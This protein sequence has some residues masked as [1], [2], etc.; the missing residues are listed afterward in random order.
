MT[1]VTNLEKGL[2]AYQQGDFHSA[3][4]LLQ[5]ALRQAPNDPTVLSKLGNALKRS[6]RF[7]EALK[8][9]ETLVQAYPDAPEALSDLGATLLSWGKIEASIGY[10]QKAVALRPDSA[11]LNYNLAVAE[12]YADLLESAVGH[13]RACTS[14]VPT[15]AQAWSNLGICLK[16]LGCT[17]EALFCQQHAAT[18][19]PS[20][21]DIQW[22][23]SLT[24]LLNGNYQSGFARYE[25]RRKLPGYQIVKGKLW[26]G[27]SAPNQMLTVVAEQGLGDTLQ[28][29]RYLPMAKSRV[30]HLRLMSRKALIPLL[31][32]GFQAVDE[33]VP[34]DTL[35]DDTLTAPLMSLPHLLDLPSPLPESV[36]YLRAE[37]S[38]IDYWT[39]LLRLDTS[40]H[41]GIAWQGNPAHRDDRHRSIS[42]QTLSPILGL[43]EARFFSL[44]KEH[45]LFELNKTVT[46]LNLVDIG[47]ALDDDGAFVDTAAVMNVLDL[48]L[49]V[50]TSVAHLAGA[51]GVE[52]W[53]LLPYAPDFRW[54][55]GDCPLYPQMR[56]FRQTRR[57]D[58]STVIEQVRAALIERCRANR[59]DA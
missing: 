51:L 21:P 50:D 48:V 2:A 44:Q 12:Q 14:R 7:D 45:G 46:G 29:I 41:V 16:A 10:F 25:W 4:R 18:C 1:L 54:G 11:E 8:I 58:W 37:S 59:G 32:N 23:L 57:N 56:L 3:A 26:D 31:K 22:N 28:F 47:G 6:G 39:G 53:T 5:D 49:T 55:L 24:E 43:K 19:A 40:L 13:Y 27:T 35:S 36:P 42:I 38:R 17:D 20:N 30:G 33:I 9:H 34:M 15:H 52:T